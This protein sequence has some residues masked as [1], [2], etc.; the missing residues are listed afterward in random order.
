MFSL[1]V[2]ADLVGAVPAHAHAA[3]GHALRFRY[4]EDLAVR[5]ET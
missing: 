1:K 3:V 2:S 5:V 4:H